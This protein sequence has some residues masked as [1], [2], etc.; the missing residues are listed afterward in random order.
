MNVDSAPRNATL[1]A[2]FRA[3][4]FYI[5]FIYSI[6]ALFPLYSLESG[7]VCS[8]RTG[9]RSA[10]LGTSPPHQRPTSAE[11]SAR[12]NNR[13]GS[14]IFISE[15]VQ[16]FAVT[17]IGD[18]KSIHIFRR[19]VLRSCLFMNCIPLAGKRRLFNRGNRSIMLLGSAGAFHL[20]RVRIYSI[21]NQ[22]ERDSRVERRKPK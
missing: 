3:I 20:R 2:F 4:N 19:H 13:T 8:A 14:S 11:Q 5:F 18:P 21:A 10:R 17:E 12:A 16:V 22:L 7:A 6:F 9:T 15:K 1:F